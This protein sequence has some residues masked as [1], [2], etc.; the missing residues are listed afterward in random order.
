MDVFAA[1]LWCTSWL[2]CAA[3]PPPIGAG[4]S[5]DVCVCFSN[6]CASHSTIGAYPTASD[7][8]KNSIILHCR[9]QATCRHLPS[10]KIEKFASVPQVLNMNIA[11]RCRPDV[12]GSQV[13]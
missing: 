7:S 2:P 5:V 6:M 12:K 1:C 11:I 4:M 9:G 8:V 13:Y 3:P 10:G